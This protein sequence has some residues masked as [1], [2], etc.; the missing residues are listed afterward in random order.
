MG[1]IGRM[2][3][4]VGEGGLPPGGHFVLSD[5]C[6]KLPAKAGAAVY[7]D[8]ATVRYHSEH[9]TSNDPKFAPRMACTLIM[10]QE[11][12]RESEGCKRQV[13]HFVC[14]PKGA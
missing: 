14:L 7:L 5:W 3:C 13:V 6:I 12:R 8:S 2:C 4:C 11:V 10:S 1:V 9:C